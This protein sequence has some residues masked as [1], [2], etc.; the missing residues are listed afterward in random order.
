MK[1]GV[2]SRLDEMDSV[3][4]LDCVEKGEAVCLPL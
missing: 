2:F 3:V 4:L 1:D